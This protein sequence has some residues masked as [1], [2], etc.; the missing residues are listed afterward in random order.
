MESSIEITYDPTIKVRGITEELF[1]QQ[2]EGK[3]VLKSFT[4]ISKKVYKNFND[5]SHAFNYLLKFLKKK[6]KEDNNVI[7][8]VF[9]EPRNTGKIN[10][11]SNTIFLL[12]KIY[13]GRY[14]KPFKFISTIKH[15]INTKSVID[16]ILSNEQKKRI[17]IINKS[18]SFVLFISSLTIIYLIKQILEL[19]FPIYTGHISSLLYE[20]LKILLIVSFTFV[21]IIYLLTKEMHLRVVKFLDTYAVLNRIFYS[22]EKFKNQDSK[23]KILVINLDFYSYFDETTSINFLHHLLNSMKDNKSLF[24]ILHMQDE[25][26]LTYFKSELTSNELMNVSFFIEDNENEFGIKI[27][28]NSEF[29]KENLPTSYSQRKS[30]LEFVASIQRNRQLERENKEQLARII[31]S[32]KLDSMNIT[33]SGVSHEIGNPLSI[34]QLVIENLR[35]EKNLSKEVLAKDLDKIQIQISR[36]FKLTET[37]QKYSSKKNPTKKTIHSQ[38]TNA[39]TFFEQRLLSNKIEVTYEKP[40]KQIA[41]ME[42]SEE[43]AIVIENLIS[44]SIDALAENKDAIIKIK[45]SLGDN[46]L[47]LLFSDNGNGIPKEYLSEVFTP[48]FTTKGPGKGTGL[49]LWLCYTI[50]KDNLKGDIRVDS[51]PNQGTT[52]T[53]SLP[54]GGDENVQ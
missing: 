26:W 28:D 30:Y 49:G 41:E 47:Y 23:K 40:E 29:D 13:F 39:I 7:L 44:N 12:F 33:A 52:F 53:I 1:K 22:M 8:K 19:L 37:F 27:I 43:L 24:I 36:I 16:K 4:I 11:L 2:P 18:I 15:L 20:I 32:A 9:S 35:M 38:I 51:E 50:I 46:K 54:V 45:I 5:R 42:F 6:S 3:F 14:L 17:E 31:Q 21:Y 25:H 34:I 48:L 10:S